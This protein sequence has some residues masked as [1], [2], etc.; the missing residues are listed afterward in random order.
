MPLHLRQRYVETLP[1]HTEGLLP[2]TLRDLAPDEIARQPIRVGRQAG[3]LGDLFTIDG[4]AE[5]ETLV[6]TGDL[7]S[8][9][10]LGAGLARGTLL[11]DGDA[12]PSVGHQ[13]RGGRLEVHGSVGPGAGGFM[14][15]GLLRVRGNAGD[16]LGAAPPGHR[17]GMRGGTVIVDG[18]AGQYVGRSMRRG[19]IYVA[20]DCL[21]GAMTNALAGTVIVGGR[22][23]SRAAAG[24]RRG[25]LILLGLGE[26]EILPTF[27]PGRSSRPLI[28]GLIARSLARLGMAF[29]PRWASLHYQ[30]YH[31]DLLNKGLG[32]ILVPRP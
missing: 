2:E 14:A 22:C 25:T 12:G 8:M 1:I 6:M 16:E 17:M 29:D 28:L 13:M 23:G 10:G 4:S 5:D 18:R 27:S 21:E 15:G 3:Q 32:E 30:V 26:E 31:G 11:I 20:G 24:M 7:R 9:A 19:T